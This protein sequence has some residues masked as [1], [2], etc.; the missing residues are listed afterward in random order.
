MSWQHSAGTNSFLIYNFYSKSFYLILDL[1]HV[2]LTKY[3]RKK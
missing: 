2:V 3:G 1:L